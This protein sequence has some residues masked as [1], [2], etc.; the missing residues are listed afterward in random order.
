MF[1]ISTPRSAATTRQVEPG[2]PNGNISP[3]GI[4]ASR[5]NAGGPGAP[6]AAIV[7]TQQT[8]RE[9]CLTETTLRNCPRRA[10]GETPVPASETSCP[11]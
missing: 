3:V 11:V 6:H 8:K 4:A 1:R 2:G 7:T 5:D 9:T 10:E